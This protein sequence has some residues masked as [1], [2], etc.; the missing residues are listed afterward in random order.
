MAD[1]QRQ[2]DEWKRRDS[3]VSGSDDDLD[4]DELG[5]DHVVE[6]VNTKSRGAP[7]RMAEDKLHEKRL[8]ERARRNGMAKSIDQMRV[9][10]PELMDSKKVYSQAKVV[11]IALQH[12]Y[13][14]QRENGDLRQRLG[15]KPRDQEIRANAKGKRSQPQSATSQ[16]TAAVKREMPPIDP[17]EERHTKRRRVDDSTSTPTTMPPPQQSASLTPGGKGYSA[18]PA[19]AVLAL[20]PRALSQQTGPSAAPVQVQFSNEEGVFE[21]QVLDHSRSHSPS[22]SRDEDDFFVAD[23]PLTMSPRRDHE[24]DVDELY[25]PY[26]SFAGASTT[27]TWEEHDVIYHH[28]HVHNLQ[29]PLPS[30]TVSPHHVHSDIDEML[31]DVLGSTA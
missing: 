11:A 16:T 10:V 14:L 15:L 4:V 30:H 8:K 18:P 20:L 1:L 22:A 12:I 19:A 26:C 3:D 7:K 17:A 27:S 21:A 29:S 28:G 31:Q 6:V 9:I 23:T 2:H 5:S 13:D 25:S 24:G